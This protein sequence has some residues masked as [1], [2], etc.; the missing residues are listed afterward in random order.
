LAAFGATLEDVTEDVE[1]W[2]D[3]AEAAAVFA[4]LGT[5]WRHG[6]NGPTGLIY[7][8]IWPTARVLR[9]PRARW[10]ELLD[11]LQV[12]ERAVLELRAEKDG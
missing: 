10:A 7:E 9:V 3:N 8:A 12:M 4:K 1:V 5:Q 11:S 2:P 6:M